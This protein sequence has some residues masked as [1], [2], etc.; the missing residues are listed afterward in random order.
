MVGWKI[1]QMRRNDSIVKIGSNN[2]RLCDVDRAGKD[3]IG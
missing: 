1:V 2:D 3:R